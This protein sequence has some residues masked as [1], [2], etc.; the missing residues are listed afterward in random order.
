MKKQTARQRIPIVVHSYRS[1]FMGK[2]GREQFAKTK[3]F[4]LAQ[5]ASDSFPRQVV[6]ED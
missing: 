3:G 4:K 5:K 2:K 1:G 6:V